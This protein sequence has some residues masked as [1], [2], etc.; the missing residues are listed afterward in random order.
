MGNCWALVCANLENEKNQVAD[1]WFACCVKEHPKLDAWLR[2]AKNQAASG[3]FSG[4][5][6]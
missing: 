6:K 1:D 5:F 3:G 2:F 4:I